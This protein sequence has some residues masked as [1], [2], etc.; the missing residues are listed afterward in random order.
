MT[1]ERYL[2][3][4]KTF[5]H[6]LIIAKGRTV[7]LIVFAWVFG[8]ASS[9]AFLGSPAVGMAKTCVLWPESTFYHI[10]PRVL[11]TFSPPSNPIYTSG[12]F[13]ILQA[14]PFTLAMIVTVILYVLIIQKLS[15]RVSQFDQGNQQGR[16]I[17]KVR[18]NVAQLL[19]MNGIVFFL[20]YIPFYVNRFNRGLLVITDNRVGYQMTPSTSGI[21]NWFTVCLATVNSFINPVIYNLTNQRYRRAFIYVFTCK[22]FAMKTK[23]KSNVVKNSHGY[24][25][26]YCD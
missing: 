25:L 5:Y 18:D 11:H 22:I 3:I 13:R 14:I 26:Q 15:K 19:I 8:L 17:S 10:L 16:Q 6:R 24:H 9:C 7:K 2:G 12:M 1:V 20:A 4:C 21:V 23:N